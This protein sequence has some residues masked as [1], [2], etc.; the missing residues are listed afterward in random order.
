MERCPS[1]RSSF[2]SEGANILPQGS[3]S[4]AEELFK[5]VAKVDVEKRVDDRVGDIVDEVDVK[6]NRNMWYYIEQD[7]NGREEGES[8]HDGDNEEHECYLEVLTHM[9]F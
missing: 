1:S 3:S 8:E 4:S 7:E 2:H 6:D 5:F 9:N